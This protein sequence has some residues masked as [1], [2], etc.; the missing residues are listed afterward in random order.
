MVRCGVIGPGATGVEESASRDQQPL[1]LVGGSCSGA[2]GARTSRIAA[3]VPGGTSMELVIRID[4]PENTTIPASVTA[5]IQA[6]INVLAH[7]YGEQV[8]RPARRRDEL[9]GRV[10]P[11]QRQI[12]PMLIEGKTEREI[13]S[14]MHRSPHTVHD[15]VKTIYATLG[16]ASRFELL[17]LWGE[18]AYESTAN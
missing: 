9:L 8:A 16:I 10:S 2:P 17:A 3:Q 6:I 14:A 7:G 18:P 4:S 13:A 15:H 12:L 11:S 1:G 5:L